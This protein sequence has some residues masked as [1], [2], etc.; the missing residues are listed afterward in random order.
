MNRAREKKPQNSKGIEENPRTLAEEE[1]S[2]EIIR[3]AR[4]TMHRL[5]VYASDTNK[6]GFSALAAI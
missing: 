5:H 2:N 4:Q 3:C 6:E 1:K